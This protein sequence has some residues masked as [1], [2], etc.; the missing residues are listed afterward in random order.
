MGNNHQLC[1]KVNAEQCIY[2]LTYT[3]KINNA[4]LPHTEQQLSD[5]FCLLFSISGSGLLTLND[6]RWRLKNLTLYTMMP[7]ETFMLKTEPYQKHE[8]YLFR[9]Q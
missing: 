2:R 3:E 4:D 6:Q 9:F 5:T 8:L 7:G 1:T